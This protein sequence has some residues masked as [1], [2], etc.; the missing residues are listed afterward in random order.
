MKSVQPIYRSLTFVNT[1]LARALAFTLALGLLA[2]SVSVLLQVYFRYVVQ[3]ALPWSE[4]LSRYL[5]VYLS[6]GGGALAYQRGAHVRLALFQAFPKREHA[7]I[8]RFQAACTL[9]FGVALAWGGLRLL[10]RNVDQTSPAMGVSMGLPNAAIPLCGVLLV[11]FALERLFAPAAV[12]HEKPSHEK[13]SHEKPPTP[14]F[15]LVLAV[16]WL[17]LAGVLVANGFGVAWLGFL[18]A[19]TQLF[20][21]PLLLLTL[22]ALL[23]VLGVP[24]ALVIA[25]ASLI[26]M[27][28]SGSRLL[29]LPSRMFAGTDSFPLLAVPLF[30]LAGSLMNTGGITRR[31]VGF[32]SNLVGWLRGGLAL[33][34]IQASMF[35]AGI[36]GS[37]VADASAVGGVLIPA[38]EEDGYEKDFAAAVTAASSTV[39]PIIPPSIPLVLYGILAQVSVG[40]LFLA[41]A[42]P[43]LLLGLSMMALTYVISVRRGYKA[44]PWQGWRNLGKSFLGAFWALITPLIILGGILSGIFT[45][46]EASAVAVGY[47]FITGAFIYRELSWRKLPSMLVEATL[48]TALIMFVVAAAQPMAFVFARQ[49]VPALVG[50]WLLSISSS[51]WVLIPLVNVILLLVGTVL[52]TTA[53]L[54][55]F[56]PILLPLMTSIGVDPVW[57]GVMMVLNLIIGLVTPPVGVVLF[58]TSGIANLPLEDLIRAIW[59]YL[60]VMLVVLALVAGFP[61]LS[62][63]LPGVF[64]Y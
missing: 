62:L 36:S 57:F 29:L 7:V 25:L 31:L 30:V 56:I 47:A 6:F 37:A 63:W 4:E 26:A 14:F 48:V 52:E 1:L 24:I 10:L 64:G 42:I 38:M 60:L 5:L 35:F 9:L 15:T 59:P 18:A 22:F 11:L 51:P 55:I 61:G 20:S 44:H 12:P 23:L 39:G 32:A 40:A 49:Q 53:A 46:T 28:A 33:V 21:V 58:V 54:I 27:L 50:D 45:A 43:G 16:I 19:W 13:P 17:G 2:M 8:E 34:N 41:G 3:A